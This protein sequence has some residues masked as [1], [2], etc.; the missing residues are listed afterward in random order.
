MGTQAERMAR[1]EAELELMKESLDEHKKET[2]ENFQELN[3]KMDQLLA[4]RHK[5]VGAFWLA[6]SLFGTGL[7]SFFYWLLGVK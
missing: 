3:G 7:L 1:M 2:K 6:S 5:G 4:L